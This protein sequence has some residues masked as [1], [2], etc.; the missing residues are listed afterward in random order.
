MG[1]SDPRAFLIAFTALTAPAIGMA[2]CKL[3]KVAEL[4]VTMS[5]LRPLV[6][7]KIN[8]ADALFV[9]D[10][11]AFYSMMS[12]A[13][14]ERYQLKLHSAPKR[15]DLVGVGGRVEAAATTVEEFTVASQ[16]IRNIEFLVGG[17]E[18]GSG[19]VGLLG[20]NGRGVDRLRMGMSA[21]GRSVIAAAVSIR[22]GIEEEAR[23]YGIAP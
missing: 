18:A 13:N 8:G 3:Y 20:Q 22:S 7:A 10:S 6:S 12:E 17:S 23:R 16:V 1:F 19:A 4:P 9:V 14:A 11:G 15:L 2:E 21:E 5:G